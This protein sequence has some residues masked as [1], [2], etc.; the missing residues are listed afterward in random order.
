MTLSLNSP[1]VYQAVALG[2]PAV[3]AGA[4]LF[5]SRKRPFRSAIVTASV[6]VGLA[7]LVALAGTFLA[8]PEEATRSLG[9][10]LDVVTSVMLLLVTSMGLTVLRYSRTY[11]DGD[12]GV[13]RYTRWLLA[14]LAAVSTLVIANNLALFAAAWMATSLSLH[15]LL[16]F[17]DRPAAQVAAHK[18]FLASRLADALLI[19]G[20][21][22]IYRATGTLDLDGIYAWSAANSELS[23]FLHAAAFLVVLAACVKSAQLPLHGWLTQ[24]MEAPTPVSA[25][26]HAGVVNIG[27]FLMIRLAPFM[28]H[29]PGAQLLL[30]CIGM[31]TTVLAALIMTTR[32]S[33]KVAL[34][35]STCA[36]M[37]FM[38]VQC[39]L[40][41][42]HLALLHLV[43]HSLYKAH[44]FL[45]SG[46]T[47][48][49]W[50]V[51]S[52]LPGPAPVPLPRT[53]L[54]TALV[55]G[56]AGGVLFTLVGTLEASAAQQAPLLILTLIVALSL[57][58]TASRALD[59]GPGAA[60]RIVLQGAGIA[61]LYFGWH[62]A[63][64]HVFALPGATAGALA[65]G[66]ATSAGWLI[67]ATG[68][69]GLFLVQSVLQARP[70][71]PFARRI[72][73]WLCLLYPSPSPRD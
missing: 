48:D 49:V 27:G 10:R 24:V 73:P 11:L 15:Q 71:G 35:W 52:L 30:V 65:P 28:A 21:L 34:A 20:F 68:F 43:A 62:A 54:A 59:A 17:Y 41:A 26:L 60:P 61:L 3:L 4:A 44:A 18:K 29:A 6:S 32:V 7:V 47:V 40:G 25:L 46:G 45:S 39:G 56:A 33:I 12:P 66:S 5:V 19:T 37:G 23:P 42:W 72:Y 58:P 36:Q 8:A 16:T 1:L 63:A 55:L 31:T 53:A 69:V 9:V 50:R 64:E 70:Q 67:V 51:R 38:L 22:L 57:V 13:Q 14:T 2:V